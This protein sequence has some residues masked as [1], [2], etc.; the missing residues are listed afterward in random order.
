M[1]W[2]F[3]DSK[4]LRRWSISAKDYF[5]SFSFLL[6]EFKINDVQQLL[7]FLLFLDDNLS[8]LFLELVY[9]KEE[10]NDGSLKEKP[11]TLSNY[12]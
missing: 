5:A 6:Q 10:T 2:K 12:S 7:H 3:E 4:Q 1:N 11:S 9:K 8:N